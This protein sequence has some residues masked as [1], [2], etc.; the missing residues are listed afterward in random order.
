MSLFRSIATVG[1]W[2]MGSRL[3]GFVR[4]ILMA[5]ALGTGMVADAFFVAFKFPNFFRRLFAEGAFNAAFVPLFGER[6][7]KDGITAA[8]TFAAEAAA[9]MV[10]ALLTFTLLAIITMPILMY[11][12]APGFAGHSEKFE[13]TIELTR[14]TFPYLTFMALIALMGGML[15]TMQKFAA[16]AAAPILLNIVLI[17][18]LV[19]LNLDV[20]DHPGFTLAW[21]VCAAGIGQFIWIVA[22]CAK[23]K[24]LSRL[25]WP[26]LTPGVKRLLTLMAPGLIGAGVVQINLVVDVILA[27]TLQE[28]SVS[29]L[30]FAD[31]V[32]QL[33]LGVIG[34]AVGVALLP[35]MTRQLA[36]GDEAG[37]AESQNRAIEFALLL[38]VP[39][40]LALVTIGDPI[41]RVLF[42]RGAFDAAATK[43][44]AA[45][46]SAFSVGLP[47]Y[48][49]IKALT[50]GFFARQD[51]VTPVK[52]AIVAMVVNV[53]LA[54][55]LMQVLSHVGIALAT[56]GSAWMNAIILWV[57]LHRRGQFHADA[58]LWN[59]GIRTIAVSLVMAGALFYAA[60]M[61]STYL[62]GAGLERVAALILLVVF[63]L[64]LFAVLA[65][66]CGAMKVSELRTMLR[67]SPVRD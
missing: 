20:F 49:L 53:V 48:V 47:A 35:L 25:S 65:H 26:R 28:G 42:E 57:I 41:V 30:Y 39:A 67:R 36:E 40:T 2:T 50:P 29:F 18:A 64:A 8:R 24:L 19:L 54:L 38:T 63:G 21:A 37:A 27:S 52:I 32:N 55:I 23:G 1:S 15:N 14:I 16:T 46:L 10:A 7:E 56:A 60:S 17:S 43:N 9:V 31:R 4:D 51:T 13:L 59:R 62:T 44:T 11:L 5:S 45:A 34:V 6:L 58:R 61:L 66:Y 22:A 12:I 3:L 33:P